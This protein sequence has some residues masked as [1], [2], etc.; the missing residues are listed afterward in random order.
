VG[1]IDFELFLADLEAAFGALGSGEGRRPP[2]WSTAIKRARHSVN[3][4]RRFHRAIDSHK[5]NG[6][7]LYNALAGRLPKSLQR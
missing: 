2:Y 3:G 7:A 4:C 1:V 5:V 6:V